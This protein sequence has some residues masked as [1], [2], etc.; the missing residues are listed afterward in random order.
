MTELLE[1]IKSRGY[2]RVLVRPEKYIAERVDTLAKCETL[3]EENQVRHRGWYFPHTD[4]SRTRNG[5]NYVELQTDFRGKY[6]AWRFYQSGQFAFWSALDEDWLEEFPFRDTSNLPKFKPG[7]SLSVLS[8][9]FRLSEIYEFASRLA[10]VGLFDDQLYLSIELFGTKN[11][12]M[13]FWTPDRSM[14]MNCLCVE[15]SLPRARTFQTV[16]FV[17]RARDLALEH[18]LWIAE[19]FQCRASEHVFRRDQEKFF[20]GHY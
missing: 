1:K 8:T 12:K 15:P 3:V 9:L 13:N 20:E 5:L 11:R 19:R 4:R 17:P 16:D 7:E 6:E 14:G 18:F 10:Q 2:W